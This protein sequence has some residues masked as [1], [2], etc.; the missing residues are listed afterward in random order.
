MDLG[1]C[2]DILF[3]NIVGKYVGIYLWGY[4]LQFLGKKQLGHIVENIKPQ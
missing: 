1:G 3:G 2:G 4:T